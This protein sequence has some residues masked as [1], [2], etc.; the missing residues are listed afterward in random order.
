MTVAATSKSKP[1][2]R[3]GDIYLTPGAIEV[4]NASR[5]DIIALLRRH[6]TGDWGDLD[7]EDKQMNEDALDCGARIFS[8]YEVSSKKL[9]IITEADRSATTVLKPDEY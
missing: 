2:F 6:V 8:S 7:S 5:Q 9:W 1:L 4:L 3:L